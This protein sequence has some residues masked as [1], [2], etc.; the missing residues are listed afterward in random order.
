M[1]D[2][3]GISEGHKV[4]V[5]D[6]GGGTCDLISYTIKSL[7]PTLEV[8]EAAPGSGGLCG[9]IYLNKA[10]EHLLRTKLGRQRGFDDET[11]AD[12]LETFERKVRDGWMTRQ[13]I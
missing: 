10:F 5:V 2:Q 1:S 13:D 3:T 12:A 8:E 4:I 6:A 7:H 9:S 11:V